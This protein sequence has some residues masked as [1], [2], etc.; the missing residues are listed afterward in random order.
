MIEAEVE[1][2]EL[3][4]EIPQRHDPS[5]H[6]ARADEQHDVETIDLLGAP[7]LHVCDRCD[8]Q[9]LG[10]DTPLKLAYVEVTR[11]SPGRRPT[12]CTAAKK[13]TIEGRTADLRRIHQQDVSPQ[14]RPQALRSAAELA[15]LASNQ[16]R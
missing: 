16:S 11:S 2:N 14:P 1:E 13:S 8:L 10:N 4:G 5:H 3:R 9:S 7:T 15:F 6:L 12:C